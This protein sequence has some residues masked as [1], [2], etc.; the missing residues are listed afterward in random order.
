MKNED[1]PFVRVPISDGRVRHIP[2]D[3]YNRWLRAATKAKMTISE[4][5]A[6]VLR[7]AEEGK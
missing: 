3:T 5:V 2:V 4:Y 7:K 6:A 1:W